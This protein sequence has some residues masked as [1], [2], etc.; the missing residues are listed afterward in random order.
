MDNILSNLVIDEVYS[1]TAMYNE[2][3]LPFERKNRPCWAVLIKYEGETVY[4]AN[5][6]EF[7]SNAE[8]MVILPKGSNYSWQ[9]IKAGHFFVI[10][11]D[12]QLQVDEIFV[13]PIKN[14]QK[15]LSKFR[16]IEQKRLIKK[17]FYQIESIKETYSIILELL[18]SLEQSYTP[19]SKEQKL[20]PAI[21]YIGQNYANK[22]TNDQLADICGLSTVYFRKLF[23]KVFGV[24]PIN[25]V[26]GVRIKKAKEMLKS[27]FSSITDIALSLG[28][29]NI[30]DFS[31]DFKKHVGVA[32]SKFIEK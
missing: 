24:P 6:K 4:R 19:S 29:T 1:A 21:E 7:V 23:T 15:M 18:Q 9:C 25:Y 5:G 13:F 12:S 3:N 28:Y 30:Y 11:F 20:L 14:S 16:A 27:D 26:I 10:E 32:P 2:E 22:I 17:P 8:N 31:R